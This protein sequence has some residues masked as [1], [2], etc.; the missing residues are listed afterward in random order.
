[1]AP[2]IQLRQ[3]TN[4]PC[5]TVVVLVFIQQDDA[6]LLAR[7]DYGQQYWSLPGGVMEPGESIDEAAIR[8]VKEE[9]GL[10]VRLRRVVGLY[11]KPGED[12]LAVCFEGEVIGGT[13]KADHEITECR[14]FP[15]DRLPESIR[16]H[17]RQRIE[18][19]RGNFSHVVIRTQ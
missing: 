1:M 7:Q 17:L 9:T 15:H 14:Y 18:D 5:V 10:D 4:Q 11:S 13:L 16:E 19:F 2:S 6:I 8:E 3:M 12:G